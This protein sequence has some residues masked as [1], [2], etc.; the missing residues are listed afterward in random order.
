MQRY[1]L[2]TCATIWFLQGDKRVANIAE[3]IQ[4]YEAD[5]AL[6]ID[7]IRELIYLKG[8]GKIKIDMTFKQLCDHFRKAG[9]KTFLFDEE[10]LRAMYDMP[11]F[12][13]HTDPTDRCIIAQAIADKRTLISADKKFERYKKY[14][15][16]LL[17]I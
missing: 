9:I 8:Y 7:V 17:S 13:D 5:F 2:D 3:S 16:K 1:Y 11:F 14:G 4:Y 12:S 15:L 10:A 6:P